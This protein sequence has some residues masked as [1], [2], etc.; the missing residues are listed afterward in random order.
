[1]NNESFCSEVRIGLDY[2]HIEYTRLPSQYEMYKN[3]IGLIFRAESPK[4]A[5]SVFKSYVFLTKNYKKVSKVMSDKKWIALEPA[6]FAEGRISLKRSINKNLIYV[7]NYLSKTPQVFSVAEKEYRQVEYIK[8][9]TKTDLPYES[10]LEDG[11]Y[12]VFHKGG[13]RY[14]LAK[15]TYGKD[16]KYFF[17]RIEMIDETINRDEIIELAF[18]NI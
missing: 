12:N 11:V 7:T 18:T 17:I 16:G 13:L 8:S 5:E 1:M 6:H 10:I 3:T 2:L 4:E 14:P 15:Y 9:N